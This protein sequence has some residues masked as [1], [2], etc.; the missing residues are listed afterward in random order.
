MHIPI[1]PVDWWGIV[2]NEALLIALIGAVGTWLKVRGD[3]KIRGLEARSNERIKKLETD[4]AILSASEAAAVQKALA[5]D[6]AAKELR[7]ALSE[8]VAILETQIAELYR[9]RE[10]HVLISAVLFDLLA[11]YPDPPGAPRIPERVAE[12]IGWVSDCPKPTP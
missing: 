6:Q 9:E 1:D 11:D 10:I 12:A 3:E 4:S 7:E 8:R 5:I 2:G